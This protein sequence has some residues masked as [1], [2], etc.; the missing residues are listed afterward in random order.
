MAFIQR[1]ME[2]KRLKQNS[3]WGWKAR[4]DV[5]ATGNKFCWWHLYTEVGC[6]LW[7]IHTKSFHVPTSAAVFEET[8]NVCFWKWWMPS[9]SRSCLPKPQGEEGKSQNHLHLFALADFLTDFGWLQALS[10]AWSVLR[11]ACC[12]FQGC[13]EIAIWVIETAQCL[14]G[15]KCPA[16]W[17]RCC[18][19]AIYNLSN[20]M[21]NWYYLIPWA[22]S[23]LSKFLVLH[24]SAYSLDYLS[25]FWFIL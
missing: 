15:V 8:G 2:L 16:K 19:V 21:C 10:L 24:F 23:L 17:G 1:R 18:L 14:L 20:N 22:E 3:P 12:G 25:W 7:L 9:S 4:R 5:L 11:E 6:N 13:R